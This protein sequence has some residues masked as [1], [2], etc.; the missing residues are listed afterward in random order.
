MIMHI[1]S[2]SI[3]AAASAAAVAQGPA[4]LR[5]SHSHLIATC[6]NGKPID[7]ERHWRVTA[8]VSITATMQNEPRAG[9]G[10]AA[11]GFAVI[12]FTPEP[13][14]RYEIEVRGAAMM[15]S[16]RVWPRGEWK[17]VVRDRT[18]DRVVSSEPRWTE[19]GCGVPS[20]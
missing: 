15:F 9:V 10:N 17:A 2:V 14:H 13:G 20:R 16:C 11:P 8:P 6:I 5:V 7:G 3:V 4:D 18:T 12:D 1:L 19:S